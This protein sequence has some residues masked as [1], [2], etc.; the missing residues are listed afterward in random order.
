M[1]KKTTD[2]K[3]CTILTEIYNS[4]ILV[5]DEKDRADATEDIFYKQMREDENYLYYGEDGIAKA[6]FSYRKVA[7]AVY[8]MTSLYVKKEYQRAGIGQKCFTFL[9]EQ[10]PKGSILY[11]KALKNA[12]WSIA[13]YRKMGFEDCSME[14]EVRITVGK[15]ACLLKKSIK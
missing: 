4:A 6:F 10:I 15:W 8:E 2:I 14:D 13:F 5:F 1:F 3:E 7:E 12:P 9:E 11:V